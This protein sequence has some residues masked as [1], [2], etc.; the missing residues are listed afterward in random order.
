M[1]LLGNEHSYEESFPCSSQFPL[2]VPSSC[3]CAYTRAPVYSTTALAIKIPWNTRFERPSQVR[4]VLFASTY[5]VEWSD[6][7]PAHSRTRSRAPDT[8]IIHRIRVAVFNVSVVK[9]LFQCACALCSFPTSDIRNIYGQFK[10]TRILTVLNGA[11]VRIH[12]RARE[13]GAAPR[14]RHMDHETLFMMFSCANG[15][16]CFWFPPCSAPLY[17]KRTSI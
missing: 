13:C 8:L 3:V 5:K 12:A 15:L 4:P 11:S 2:N 6:H 14:C 9:V 16:V 7:E 17:A 1:P 10:R